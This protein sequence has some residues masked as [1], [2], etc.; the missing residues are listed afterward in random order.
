MICFAHSRDAQRSNVG[1]SKLIHLVTRNLSSSARDCKMLHELPSV[2][3]AD[4]S[5]AFA[6]NRPIF[7][8]NFVVWMPLYVQYIHAIASHHFAIL[9]LDKTWTD[10]DVDRLGF[11]MFRHVSEFDAMLDCSGRLSCMSLGSWVV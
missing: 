10:S 9:F 4:I 2:G 7:S 11:D 1:T 3:T 8:S 6:H 5:R